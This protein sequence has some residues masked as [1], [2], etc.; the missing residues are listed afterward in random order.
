[1]G[2]REGAEG[3]GWGGGWANLTCTEAGGRE[4]LATGEST[5]AA[6]DR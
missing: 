6:G 2:R 1:M 5:M 4:R 3:E